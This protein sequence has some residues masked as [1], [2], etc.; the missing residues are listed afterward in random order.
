MQQ[1]LQNEIHQAQQ[2]QQTLLPD[3]PAT[4]PGFHV[5][6][7]YRPAEQVGGDFFQ[8]LPSVDGGLLV[9]LGDVSGKGLRAAMLVSLI[10]GTLRTFAEQDLSPGELLRGMNRRLHNRMEGGFATCVCARI[11]PDGQMTLANAG[12]LA[13][14][15][16]GEELAVPTGLPLGIVTDI[17]Y[18]ERNY[19]VSPGSRLVFVTDGVVEAR[20]RRGELYGFDRTKILIRRPVE[21]IVRAAQSFGQEDDIT[22]IGLRREAVV[23]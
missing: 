9:V 20:N 2:V 4:L 6:S 8:I 17:S 1:Q 7:L 14:Y 5:E 11:C 3:A 18:E 10:V 15:L 21:E 16:D 13:P 19:H 12:H 23:V 22:V